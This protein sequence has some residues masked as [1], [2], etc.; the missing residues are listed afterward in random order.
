M[1]RAAEG[2]PKR[3][4]CKCPNCLAI[5]IEPV[6]IPVYECP[7]CSKLLRA[8]RTPPGQSL[9]IP[10]NEN[11]PDK[12]ARQQTEELEAKAAS[13]SEANRSQGQEQ[14]DNHETNAQISMNGSDS[15]QK[16]LSVP[17]RD[18]A[19]SVL[20]NEMEQEVEIHSDV[21]NG[22]TSAG[23]LDP[24]S[25]YASKK[26]TA[27]GE[28][29]MAM[30]MEQEEEFHSDVRYGSTSVGN[31]D[32][33]SDDASTESTTIG[34]EGMAVEMEQPLD[35]VSKEGTSASKSGKSQKAHALMDHTIIQGMA[36]EME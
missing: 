5:L 28:E 30:E 32:T 26:R 17:V 22:F 4:R 8:K 21:G 24:T 19:V 10:L 13:G 23:N 7:I 9:Q 35:Y 18:E 31:V 33:T 25:Y 15:H 3:R 29:G 2:S 27:T 6:G 14:L 34:E 11:G 36:M 16:L 20:E 1:E 12:E